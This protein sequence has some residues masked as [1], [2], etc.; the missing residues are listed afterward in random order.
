MV[1]VNNV[2]DSCGNLICPNTNSAQYSFTG[3]PN[4]NVSVS[5]LGSDDDGYLYYTRETTYRNIEYCNMGNNGGGYRNG[6]IRFPNAGVVAG[7]TIDSAF[8]YLT[9]YGNSSNPGVNIRIAAN[10]TVNAKPISNGSVELGK[11]L[12]TA[13]VDWNNIPAWQDGNIYKS[14]DIKTVVQEWADLSNHSSASDALLLFFNNNSSSTNAIRAFSQWD[15]ASGQEKSNLVIYYHTESP[16]FVGDTTAPKV[17][18]VKTLNS[19][20]LEINFSEKLDQSSS[21]IKTNYTISNGISISSVV[22]SA[23]GKSITLTTSKHSAGQLYTVTVNNVKDSSGNLISA[24]GKSAQYSF[25][26][27]PRLNVTVYPLGSEDDGYLYYTRQAT[28]KDA[29]YCNMGNYGGGYRNGLVRFPNAGTVAGKMID[30]A[31]VYFTAYGNSVNSGV[32]IRI[33]ANDT[34]NALPIS[35]GSVEL[36]KVQTSAKV[37]WNNIPAWQ[38]GNIYKSPDI[39][40]VIQEWAD[41]SNHSSASDALLLFFNNNSSSTNAIRAF[42]QWDYASNQEKSKLVIYYHAELPKIAEDNEIENLPEKYELS[43]NYPNPFNPSTTIQYQIPQ[44]GLVTIKVYDLLGSEVITL[45]NE[46]KPT[47]IHKVNFDASDLASGTYIYAVKVNDFI[48][49]KKMILIK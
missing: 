18:G 31:F 5:P 30:S 14:P 39:K 12:T 29:A 17:L 33:S 6:L 34:V 10:D 1:T 7:K 22:S 25:V 19:T 43:Q 3:T 16:K 41:L 45:V 9:A 28:Y 47:G 8:V 2:K 35:T 21:I 48:S 27:T 4:L 38:D 15:Y 23:D 42:S 40:T 49:A 44:D 36:G 37:D 24:T 26:E 32:N 11:I 13:K 46:E 20:K